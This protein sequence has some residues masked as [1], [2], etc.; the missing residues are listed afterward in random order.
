MGRERRVVASAVFSLDDHQEIEHFNFFFGV[1]AVWTNQIQEILGDPDT[2]FRGM[3]D[4]RFMIEVMF[5]GLIGI[6]SHQRQ[7]GDQIN[8]LS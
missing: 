7:L 8:G 3:D 1:F 4:Q 2:L 5:L 6:G